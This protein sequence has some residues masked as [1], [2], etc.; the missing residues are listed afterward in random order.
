MSNDEEFDTLLNLAHVICFLVVAEIVRRK[1]PDIVLGTMGY[2][3]SLEKHALKYLATRPDRRTLD[4]YISLS[5]T[6]AL[7]LHNLDNAENRALFAELLPE[8]LKSLD[9]PY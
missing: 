4:L 9:V 7:E 5:A 6:K 2:G 8:V 1:Y 3:E